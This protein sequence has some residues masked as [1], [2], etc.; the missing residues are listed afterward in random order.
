VLQPAAHASAFRTHTVRN[1]LLGGVLAFCSASVSL[2][3]RPLGGRGSRADEQ[4]KAAFH[5]SRAGRV[6]C[7]WADCLERSC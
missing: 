3:S 2:P 1:G 4:F 7:R 6:P 5:S